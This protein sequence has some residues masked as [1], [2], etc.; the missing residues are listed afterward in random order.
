MISALMHPS[1]RSRIYM[2]GGLIRMADVNRSLS[3]SR[4]RNFFRFFVNSRG[5]VYTFIITIYGKLSR[6]AA[7][8]LKETCTYQVTIPESMVNVPK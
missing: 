5:K 3:V 2:V 4:T 6:F 7:M 1:P 8:L